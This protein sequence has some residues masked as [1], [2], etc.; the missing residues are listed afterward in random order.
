MRRLF[1]AALL[2]APLPL[3]SQATETK[4]RTPPQAIVDVVD[5]LPTPFAVPSPDG[6]TLLMLQTPA[7]LT[8]AD[9]S[10]PELKL[11]GVRFNPETHDQTRSN[12]YTSL[13]LV[14]VAGGAARA[15][16]GAPA[17]TRMRYATWSPDSS[18]IAFTLSTQA[19]VELWAADAATGAARRVGNLIINQSLPRRPFEWMSDSKSLVAR[20]VP[21]GHGAPPNTPRMPAGPAVQESRARKAAA[22]TYEDMLRDEAD[23]RSSSITC[24]R[25]WCASSST[26]RPRPWRRR[27]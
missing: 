18:K 24:S 20:V 5:A 13:S 6:K 22:R 3:F 27:G 7:L 1:A 19:G 9:L 25:R 10:Q 8:I 17:G 16:S 12:Y 21:A 2:L 26:A 15:V 11:A 14:P 23:A 4:Y